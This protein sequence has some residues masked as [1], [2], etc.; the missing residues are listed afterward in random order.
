MADFPPNLDDGE[1]WLPS[2]I[3]PQDEIIMP[4]NLDQNFYSSRLSSYA[5]QD[6][7]QC[8]AAYALLQNNH[9]QTVLKPPPNLVPEVRTFLSPAVSSFLVYFFMAAVTSFHVKF[10][11]LGFQCF[12]PA[13]QIGSTAVLQGGVVGAYGIGNNVTGLE[14]VYKHPFLNPV[15]SQVRTFGNVTHSFFCLEDGVTSAFCRLRA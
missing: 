10:F 14:P 5:D 12:R 6:L 1:L 7:T 4:S 3:F 2:D 9:T 13:V 8:F 11:F 15:Q